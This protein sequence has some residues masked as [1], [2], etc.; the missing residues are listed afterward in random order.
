MA[1][2]ILKREQLEECLQEAN[3]LSHISV[4]RHIAQ[5]ARRIDHTC[6]RPDATRH[7]V[8]RLADEG[9]RWNTAA[10]C[11]HPCWVA[12]ARAV[13]DSSGVKVA[14]VVGFPFGS[15]TTRAKRAEAEA[16]ILNGAEELD[17]VLNIGALKSGEYE[18]VESDIRGVAEVS[19]SAGVLLKV[20][21]ETAYLTDG[22]KVEACRRAERAGAHYVKT[23]TGFGP[24]GATAA[25]VR[26]MRAAVGPGVGVKAA[27]GIRTL[28]HALEMLRAVASRIG[29]SST[30]SILEEAQKLLTP[31]QA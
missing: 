30:V 10:V 26:L 23:S 17:M 2:V 28:D 25:D 12:A 7:D 3:P 1:S 13:L 11:V 29:T 8:L 6:L 19:K 22:E 15:T 9:K 24:S 20:I 5:L 16:A 4:F 14:T 21:L 18:R 31:A 27:G